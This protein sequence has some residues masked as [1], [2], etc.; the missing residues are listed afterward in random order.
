VSEAL[1]EW[2]IGF[3]GFFELD[4]VGEGYAAGANTYGEGIGDVL[5]CVM[6]FG[7]FSDKGGRVLG[8]S[9]G[10][11]SGIG[12]S[13]AWRGAD[14]LANGEIGEKAEDENVDG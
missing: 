6:E 10:G 13:A 2:E 11:G 8:L 4:I 3:M 1:A 12:I 9:V 14:A 7:G 5:A